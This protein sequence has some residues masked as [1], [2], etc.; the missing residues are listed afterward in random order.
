M[1]GTGQNGRQMNHGANGTRLEQ[2]RYVILPREITRYQIFCRARI[3]VDGQKRGFGSS[4]HATN[5]TSNV[6][7]GAGDNHQAIIAAGSH[8]VI[9]RLVAAAINGGA[10]CRP[11]TVGPEV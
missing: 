2:P 8:V 11:P 9:L 5:F 3:H 6:P 10:A 7:A 4:Q 1:E